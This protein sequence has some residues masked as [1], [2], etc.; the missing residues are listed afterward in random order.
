VNL[1]ADWDAPP[2]VTAFTTAR[3]GGVSA[4]GYDSFNLASHVGD[5]ADAVRQNR[6]ILMQTNGWTDEPL[7]LNQVHG[8]EI[9]RADD[10]GNGT[11]PEADGAV[12]GEPGRT[13]AILTADCLPV[14]ACDRT[15]TVVGAFHAGW[16]GLLAGV[17]ENGIRAMRRPADE[18]LAWIGPAIAAASYQVGGELR[19]AYLASDAAHEDDFAPDGPGHWRMDLAGAARR[20]LR[21]AGVTVTGGIWD[22]YRNADLWFSHRRQAPCGRMATIIRIERKA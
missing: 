4:S 13:L 14:V 18:L 20:R 8:A 19:D 17:L 1:A 3:T 16:K 10:V 21:K 12:T 6:R 9:V 7:W 2:H 11:A 22:T 15:G 5:D